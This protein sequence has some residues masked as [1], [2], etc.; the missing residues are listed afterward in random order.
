MASKK[1]KKISD[2]IEAGGGSMQIAIDLGLTQDAVNMWRHQGIPRK[3][4]PDIVKRYKVT[5]Q[6]IYNVDEG[7]RNEN[8]K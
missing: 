3:H 2:I 6:D 8:A 1:V 5:P 7:I 4:W